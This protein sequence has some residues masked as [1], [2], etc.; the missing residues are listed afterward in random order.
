[1]YQPSDLKVVPNEIKSYVKGGLVVD[2]GLRGFVPASQ[3]QLGY[4]EDL[5]QF[6][7]Q[8]L[9]LRLIEFDASKRKVVLSQK[10]ILNEEQA[11]KR[12]QLLETLKEGDIVSGVVR[13][14]ADFGVFVDIGGMD[15]LIHISEI[16]Y[17]RIKHPSEVLA[18]G[19]EVEVQVLKLDPRTNKLALGLKQ[20][21]QSPWAQ[22]GVNYP[23]NS[24]VQGKVARITPFGAF[25]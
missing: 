8:T 2:V 17:T 12:Q 25:V 11:G 5:N 23:V 19:D 15:G 1:M 13:R 14:I 3:I 18:I 22:A 10:V 4:V 20:L 7:G 6:L 21:K 9:R 16:S 24:I